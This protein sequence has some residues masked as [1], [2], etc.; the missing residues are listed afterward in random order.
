M[1]FHPMGRGSSLSGV[2]FEEWPAIVAHRLNV[3]IA[4]PEQRTKRIVALLKPY[5]ERPSTIWRPG[6]HLRLPD[7]VRA[8]VLRRIDRLTQDDQRRLL[9]WV[10]SCRDRVQLVSTTAEDLFERVAS[11]TFLA[12]LYYLLAIVRLEPTRISA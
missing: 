3:L 2:A 10:A 9:S 1:G 8:I 12:D 11:G 4:G 7:S 5:L 6:T